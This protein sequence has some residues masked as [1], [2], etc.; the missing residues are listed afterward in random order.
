[1]SY[2]IFC[3]FE[4]GAFPY[5]MAETLNRHGVKAY[6]ISLAGSC[7]GHNST[8]FHYGETC[9]EWDLSLLFNKQESARKNIR[10]LRDI[11]SRY[12]IERSFATGGK[13][14][15][16][17]EAEIDYKYWSFGSDLDIWCKFPVVPDGFPLWKKAMLY[18]YFLLTVCRDYKKSVFDASSLLIG[19]HQLAS[20]Q[21]VCPRKRLF[22]VSHLTNVAGPYERISGQKKE[23]KNEICKKIGAEKFFFSSARH[24][25]ADKKDTNAHIKGNDVMLYS[26]ARYLKLSGDKKTKLVLIR[27][28]PDVALSEKLAQELLIN[29]Y[30]VWL[31]EMQ[32]DEILPYYQG[33]L[34]CL[35]QFGTPALCYGTLESLANATPCISFFKRWDAKTPFYETVPPVFNSKNPEE[36]ADFM[37]RLSLDEKYSSELSYK[38]WLWARENCSEEKFVETFLKEMQR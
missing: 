37:W 21:R 34:L 26:F 32:R 1:M 36:I 15:L 31:D 19:P 25:W 2:L 7:S 8:K 5:M 33:A 29:D 27:K 38:S 20:Y 6:Y 18:P 28:G 22:F 17:K 10:L 35:G 4:V 9:D 13:S 23:N 11:K 30:I 12:G 14:Y 24:V 16:L 3:S